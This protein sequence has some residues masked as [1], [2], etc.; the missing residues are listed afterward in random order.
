MCPPMACGVPEVALPPGYRL[1]PTRFFGA[2]SAQL[3]HNP[4]ATLKLTA[5]EKCG[6]SGQK[7][8]KVDRKRPS[9][10]QSLRRVQ[11]G[12]CM[13]LKTK[14]EMVRPRGSNL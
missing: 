11:P 9:S 8:Q 6:L 5:R 12:V 10:S 3:R 4:C 1:K 2:R 7:G 14:R 13:C